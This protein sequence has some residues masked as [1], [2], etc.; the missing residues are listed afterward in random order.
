MNSRELGTKI[1]APH[2]L[3]DR[4][5]DDIK[6]PLFQRDQLKSSI[7]HL[8]AG[9]FHRAHQAVYLDQ[10]AELTGDLSWGICGVGIMPQDAP[11]ADGLQK[12]DCLYT[13]VELDSGRCAARIVGSMIDY[14]RGFES[15]AT[16]IEKLAGEKTRIVSITATEGG[17]FLDQSE[18]LNLSHESVKNDLRNPD[19]PRTI[20]GYLSEALATR[21][22]RGLPPFT[23]LSCDNVLGNGRMLKRSLIDFC[24]VKDERLAAWIEANATF[25]NCMVDRIT[26]ATTDVER[27]L[28][29]ERFAIDDAVPVVCEPFRQWII[30]DEFC[31][32]RPR[33][34]EAGAQLVADA[35][36]YE[37]MKL[38]LLNGAHSALAYL[39]YLFGF[40]YVH[41]VV[42]A[43]DFEHYM[44]C[45]LND[46]AG[47]VVGAVAGIDLNDYKRSV[48]ERFSNTAI[49][50]QL[51]RIC[52]D[53]SVKLPKFI[54]P[55]VKEQLERNG[56]IAALSLCTAAWM[57]YLEGVDEHGAALDVIDPD[58]ARL[59]QMAKATAGKR[60]EFIAASDLFGE[61]AQAERFL[62]EVESAENDLRQLG[63]KGTLLEFTR[64]NQ[65][66]SRSR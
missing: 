25:P 60:R 36:P 14:I 38:R 1:C 26:P 45:Y 11:T 66:G 51:K 63:I 29:R 49:K 3:A 44:Q 2:Q 5:R 65:R 57:R 48:I 41:E 7:V 16:A 30:E 37:R 27:A 53:G 54:F 8:G 33:L 46:E 35:A 56:S 43:H 6:L 10:C 58:A 12:Q 22:N 40:Q 39:G 31:L 61:L 62:A 59:T 21:M 34:E 23:L 20:Y 24:L 42:V 18:R 19:R 9:N 52:M 55:S 50:D 17:Y 64:K 15:P 47:Q 4:Q 32:G 28:V 13:V